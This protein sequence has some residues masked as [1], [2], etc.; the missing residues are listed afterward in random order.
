[1]KLVLEHEI[2]KIYSGIQKFKETTEAKTKSTLPNFNIGVAEIIVT[3][4]IDDRFF[5][6]D[7]SGKIYN[8]NS[9]TAIISGVTNPD[10]NVCDFYLVA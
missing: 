2:P 1:M 10:P 7:K 6:S 5:T 9:G 8:P 3:K 4:R